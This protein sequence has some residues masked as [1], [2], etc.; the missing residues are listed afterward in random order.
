MIR[1]P[2]RP[3]RPYTLF[4]YPTLFRSAL[5]RIDDDRVTRLLNAA[6]NFGR[7]AS[8]MVVALPAIEPPRVPPLRHSATQ[9]ALCAAPGT[10]LPVEGAPLVYATRYAQ[11]MRLRVVRESSASLDLPVTADP[12]RGG[13]IQIGRAHV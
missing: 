8:V 6:P 3:T 13:Y 9:G 11:N 5:S 12:E 2:P 1:R 4:P 10:V 7:P